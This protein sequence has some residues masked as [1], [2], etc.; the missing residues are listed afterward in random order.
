MWG[1][2]I[3]GLRY[4]KT[5]KKYF[6]LRRLTV[7]NTGA[8]TAQHT[9]P[10][11]CQVYANFYQPWGLGEGFTLDDI[12]VWMLGQ[13]HCHLLS[14]ASHSQRWVTELQFT[15]QHLCHSPPAL[16]NTNTQPCVNLSE[17]NRV[18]YF[19]EN[20]QLQKQQPQSECTD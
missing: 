4:L 16:L 20:V 19:W 6:P 14:W 12:Y 11:V 5:L 1:V 8:H 9:H 10:E 17:T 2:C 15:D 7:G 13:S 18:T 3:S